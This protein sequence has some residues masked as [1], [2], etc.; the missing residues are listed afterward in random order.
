MTELWSKELV[1]KTTEQNLRKVA[2]FYNL[3]G[4]GTVRARAR[5]ARSNDVFFIESRY[6]KSLMAVFGWQSLQ[7]FDGE[8]DVRKDML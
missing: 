3:G 8:T 1:E 4:G 5:C 6:R 2:C 7:H